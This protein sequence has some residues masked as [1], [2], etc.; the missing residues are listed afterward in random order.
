MVSPTELIRGLVAVL[1]TVLVVVGLVG[2]GTSVTEPTAV[3]RTCL[4]LLAGLV[5]LA[6]LVRH[7]RTRRAPAPRRVPADHH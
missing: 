6:W 2:V 1:A 3:L 5:T 4:A 7:E